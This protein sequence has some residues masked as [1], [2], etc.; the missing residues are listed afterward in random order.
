MRKN[1]ITRFIILLFLGGLGGLVIYVNAQRHH[2]LILHS[3]NTDYIWTQQINIGID[4]VFKSQSLLDIHYHYLNTKNFKEKE[5]QRRAG[6]AA[7]NA[8]DALHPDVLIAI[9]DEA[10]ELAAKYYVNNPSIQ[11]VHAGINGN[12]IDYGYDKADNVTG[13][14][15]RKPL[16]AIKDMLLF[17]G[18]FAQTGKREAKPS[19]IRALFL[20]DSSKSVGIDAQF[21]AT[22]DWAPVDYRGNLAVKSFKAWQD[23]ILRIDELS[24]I[25]LVGGY[26][27]LISESGKEFVPPA[28]VM[29]WTESHCKRPIIGMNVFNAADGAMLSL[30]VS[31]FEQGETAARM[32]IRI[33]KDKIKASSIPTI[34]SEQYVFAMRKSALQKHGF[35]LPSIYEA[36]ARTTNNFFE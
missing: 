27:E 33:L 18:E 5:H 24:D 32:A 22:Y 25:V 16:Q 31:P 34:S 7:R 4:R 12:F 8:I 14:L 36:F 28:E 15:E 13:I 9:D 6:I 2:I 35:H 20:S 29:R 10:Q 17:I 1:L 26:R 23:S 3:Y 30:G 11:I 19:A 21:L